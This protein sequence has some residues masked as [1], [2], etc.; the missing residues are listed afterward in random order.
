M[1]TIE[2]AAGLFEGE[3]CF[4]FKHNGNG[5]I[6]GRLGLKMTDKD[7]VEK[8]AEVVGYGNVNYLKTK[9]EWKDAYC[10]EISKTSEVRRITAA[11]LPYLGSRRAHKALDILDHIECN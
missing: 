5:R 3:G 10:W 11:M 8:F 7:I 2:W 9:D 4:S 1:H 6:Y